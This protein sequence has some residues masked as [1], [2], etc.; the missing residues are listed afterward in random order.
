MILDFIY[1]P[2]KA[3][4]KPWLMLFVGMF[5]AGVSIPMAYFVDKAHSSMIMVFLTV[6]ASMPFIYN[7]IRYE[8]NKDERINDERIL[9]KE[10]SKALEAFVFLFIGMVIAFSIAKGFLP[11]ELAS[12]LF[13][14]Q[15]ETIQNIISGNASVKGS[16][17]GILFNNINVLFLCIAFSFIYGLGAIYILTWN[18]SVLGTAIGNF[19][20]SNLAKIS[21]LAGFEKGVGYFKVFS[22]G[23]FIR[24]LPH[25]LLEIL[26]F[27]IGGLAGA[28]VSVAVVR[29]TFGTKRF[30]NIIYDSSDLILISL[31]VVVLAAIIEV[32]VTPVLFT[33]F[34]K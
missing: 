16:F 2:K 10:H 12:K 22:C 6:I 23:Y 15:D 9:L 24:Y 17:L 8:E 7:I 26:A 5:Y 27:F 11:N 19:L 30:A 3:E 21:H 20:S 34:C 13:S 33:A 31:A 25:G 29:K 1:S 32:F 28:I 4:K 18:A 14:A